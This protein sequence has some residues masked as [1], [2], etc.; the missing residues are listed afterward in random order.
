[1]DFDI[2][3]DF[4]FDADFGA[5]FDVFNEKIDDNSFDILDAER[6]FCDSRSDFKM[7]RNESDIAVCGISYIINPDYYFD[8]AFQNEY[9]IYAMNAYRITR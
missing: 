1:M 5:D 7:L 8:I 9:K 4:F 3:F 2:D 6:R